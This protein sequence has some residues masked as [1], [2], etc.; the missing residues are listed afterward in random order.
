MW[1]SPLIQVWVT[2]ASG[3]QMPGMRVDIFW[4]DGSDFFYTGL[5]PRVVWI[6]RFW[7]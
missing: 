3:E 5:Y 2:D 6:C 7:R 1:M 4:A